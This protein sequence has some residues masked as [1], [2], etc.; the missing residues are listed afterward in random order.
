MTFVST[1]S[2]DG[3]EFTASEAILKGLAP[4]GG[5]FV[6][7]EMPKLSPD[8]TL[9]KGLWYAMYTAIKPFFEGDELED[10]LEDI[11]RNAFNF[12]LPFHRQGDAKVI[13]E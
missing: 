9:E 4:D 8:F 7:K 10:E 6:P 3:K 12:P 13:M 11:C 2:R 1:R 5:L